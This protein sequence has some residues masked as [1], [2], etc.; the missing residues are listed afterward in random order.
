MFP[1]RLVMRLG[2]VRPIG[3]LVAILVSTTSSWA[4]QPDRAHLQGPT[5]G[6]GL[7]SKF[8]PWPKPGSVES[9]RFFPVPTSPRPA[10]RGPSP[11]SFSAGVPT[12]DEP[13]SP[14]PPVP[15]PSLAPNPLAA[16]LPPVPA[17][18]PR[19][20]TKPTLPTRWGL[21]AWLALGL[22]SLFSLMVLVGLALVCWPSRSRTPGRTPRR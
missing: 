15:S 21:A 22:S 13:T 3:M 8:S 16:L 2:V 18:P 4:T 14:E 20:A 19:P 6:S 5:R 7:S 11:S 12:T 17:A 9:G 10:G 1:K